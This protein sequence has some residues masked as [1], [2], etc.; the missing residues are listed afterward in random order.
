M[1]VLP[2]VIKPANSSMLLTTVS[3]LRDLTT[4]FFGAALARGVKKREEITTK[5]SK[6]FTLIPASDRAR[7]S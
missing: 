1:M 6:R 5:E 4:G 2:E 7:L 3:N